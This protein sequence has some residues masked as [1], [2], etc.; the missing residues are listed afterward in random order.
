MQWHTNR[1][2][3]FDR[4][5]L[6]RLRNWRDRSLAA[7]EKQQADQLTILG[8]YDCGPMLIGGQSTGTANFPII[9]SLLQTAGGD[10]DRFILSVADDQTI[11]GSGTDS[12]SG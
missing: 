11:F 4:A 1:Q 9:V 7:I 10:G 2:F 5:L 6:H 12:D 8:R 3:R